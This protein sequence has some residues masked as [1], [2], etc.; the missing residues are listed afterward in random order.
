MAQPQSQQD[1]LGFSLWTELDVLK[2]EN[3]RKDEE[4]PDYPDIID[5]EL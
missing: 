1:Q 5:M 2:R 3:E 4:F